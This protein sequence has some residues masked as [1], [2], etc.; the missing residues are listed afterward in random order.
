M[1]VNDSDKEYKGMILPE[2]LKL[3][4]LLFK[5]SICGSTK[6]FPYSDNL[7]FPDIANLVPDKYKAF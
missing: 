3:S 4:L 7:T 6:V 5:I 1:L 2:K